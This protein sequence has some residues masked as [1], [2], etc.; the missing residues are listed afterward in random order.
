M[1]IQL[2]QTLVNRNISIINPASGQSHRTSIRLEEIEWKALNQ[3]CAEENISVNEFCCRVDRDGNR[4]EHSR[5][6]RIRSAILDHF[7]SR[8][9]R[10]DGYNA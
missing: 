3:I 10:S 9:L 7:R 4:K 6:S 1:D 2:P 8:C 5:T